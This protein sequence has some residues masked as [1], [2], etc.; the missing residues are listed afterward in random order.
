MDVRSVDSLQPSGDLLVRA[1][2]CGNFE[3]APGGK[4]LVEFVLGQKRRNPEAS[5]GV[6]CGEPKGRSAGERLSHRR[7]AHLELGREGVNANPV[8]GFESPTEDA[9]SDDVERDV[10]VRGPTCPSRCLW[11]H[12]NIMHDR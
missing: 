2:H 9:L 6:C 1:S 5:V 12:S 4:Q 11:D 10:G 7:D 3:G 8:A